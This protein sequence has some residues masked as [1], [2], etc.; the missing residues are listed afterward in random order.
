MITNKPSVKLKTIQF[1]I[2]KKH[3]K[4]LDDMTYIS[5]NIFNCCIYTNNFF[6]EYLNKTYQELYYFLKNINNSSLNDNFK[7]Y[8]INLNNTDILLNSLHTY[9]LSYNENHNKIITNNKIIFEFIKNKLV[10]VVL[11]SN[12]IKQYYDNIVNELYNIIQPS[13]DNK[14]LIFTNVINKIFKS[15]YDKKYFLTRYQML[16]HIALTYNDTCLINDI[17]NNIYVYNNKK[18][19]YKKKIEKKFKVDLI[20]NQ[21]LFKKFVYKYCLDKNKHKL[22]AD[23]ILNL[24]DKY[25]EAINSYYGKIAKKLRANKPK[26]I[27]KNGRFNLYYFPRSFKIKNNTIKLTVGNYIFE[28]YINSTNKIYKINERKHCYVNDIKLKI[29]SKNK[30]NYI[31]LKNG[32]IHKN[33]ITDSNCIYIKLPNILTGCNIKQIQIKHYGNIFKCYISYQIKNNDIN[34]NNNN[35]NNITIENS[36]S[37]D[38]GIKNLLTIYNPTGTQH[39]IKGNKINSINEFYNK[40]IAELQSI[41]KKTHNLNT[42]NR[43]Y[44]LLTERTNKINGE[45]NRIVD[46]II[47]TY[48]TKI[49]FI[50]GYNEG[51]KIKTNIGTNNNRKFYKIPY[52]RIISKLKEK[53]IKQNKNLIINEESYTSKCDSL[54]LE[55]ICKKEVYNGIRIHRGLYLSS[56]G[57]VINADLNGAINIMRKIIKLDQIEGL[58][59][60]NPSILV[61]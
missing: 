39:I 11:H 45:I 3:N 14:K 32:Y 53:L 36:I 29:N 19:S 22:P 50:F 55:N 31:E 28:Q 10:D 21:F 4:I 43:M 6:K 17:K 30:K 8:L 42:F 24:I 49:N 2:N 58:N 5:K 26:Y 57:K 38:T 15:F 54:S 9:Y 20:S 1:I 60:F 40:K 18:K 41:N 51:W 16:N 37:I 52:A 61:A 59:I 33:K 34:I 56:T 44:S 46:K 25:S 23:V 12:N 47:N 48:P 27:D 35:N 7:K 13:E